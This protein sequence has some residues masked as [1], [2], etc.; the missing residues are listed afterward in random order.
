MFLNKCLA[1]N[2]PLIEYAFKAHQK[3][4]ILPDTYLLNQYMDV[5]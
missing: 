1:N 4:L 2:R 5:K 3:G